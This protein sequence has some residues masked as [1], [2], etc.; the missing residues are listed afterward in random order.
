MNDYFSTQSAIYAKSRPV[1]PQEIFQF[2]LSLCPEYKL[3][4]DCGTGNGQTA[5]VLAAT[6]EK[7]I[8]TDISENQLA[9]ARQKPNITYKVEPAEN[10]SLETNSADLI[11]VATALH[12]MDIPAFYKEAD[13]V[14]KS[15]G[16]LAVWSYAGCTVNPE[17]D[18]LFNDYANNFLKDYWPPQIRIVWE[19]KYEHL[20]FPYALIPVPEFHI[21]AQYNLPE[22]LN[23]LL[24][25]S[26]S[27]QYIKQHGTSPLGKIET[28]LKKVWPDKTAKKT[29]KWPLYLKCGR[30][31]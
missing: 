31:P 26:A 16:V 29:V 25:W 15:N 17:I 7:V 11:T 5:A 21:E 8:A 1:Y 2:I 23:Y 4:W 10:S 28:E 3:A 22:F 9:N 19:D 18:A 14:L 20:P 30:K 6:F 27:Q 24:S 13:R 12:W